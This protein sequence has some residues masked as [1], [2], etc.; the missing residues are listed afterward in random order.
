MPVSSEEF[1]HALG[2]FASGVTVVTAISQQRDLGLTV[3]AFCSVSLT[4]PYILVCIDKR[5]SAVSVMESTK[6]F[7]VNFLAEDQRNLSN[8]FASK[9]ED[10]FA[11]VDWFHGELGMPLLKNALAQ[12]ECRVVQAVEAGDHILFIGEVESA[13][14]DDE[15]QPLLYFNGRYGAFQG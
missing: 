10:K 5:S 9:L 11:D 15:K 1:R 6:T 4:P 7:G 3:S 12:L 13:M 8:H 14:V 2:R